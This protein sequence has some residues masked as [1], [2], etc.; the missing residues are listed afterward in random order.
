MNTAGDGASTLFIGG[1]SQQLIQRHLGTFS[2]QNT[3]FPRDPLSA[4]ISLGDGEGALCL[5]RLI[6]KTAFLRWQWHTSSAYEELRC[7]LKGAC[8]IVQENK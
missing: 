4:A 3:T 2:K 6:L 8:V 5:A 7:F 1:L